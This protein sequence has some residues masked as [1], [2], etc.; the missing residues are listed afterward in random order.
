MFGLGTGELIIILIIALVIFGGSKIPELGAALGKG[1]KNFK[2]GLSSI[3]E[4]ETKKEIEAPIEPGKK[5]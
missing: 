1:I 3:D 4:D 5:K 2:K